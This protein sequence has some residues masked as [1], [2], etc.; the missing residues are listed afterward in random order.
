MGEAASLKIAFIIG[1]LNTGGASLLVSLLMRE[2]DRVGISVALYSLENRQQMCSEF[3]RH[4]LVCKT[5]GE[6]ADLM[7]DRVDW[8]LQQLRDF[9][10][11]TVVG[12]LGGHSFEVLRFLPKGPQRIGLI[13]A[14]DPNVFSMAARY[15]EVLDC[16]A[17]NSRTIK[18]RLDDSPHFLSLKREWCVSGVQPPTVPPPNRN[19]D[20]SLRIVT[21]SRIN[22]EQKRVHLFPEILAVLESAARP[23]VWTI[24]GD[25]PELS[26]LM[27]EMNPLA[28]FV[29]IQFT[30]S[31]QPHEV[32][33]YLYGQDVFLLT[34]DYEGQPL[35]MIHAM[36]NGVVPVVS[37]LESGIPEL[38]S[39]ATG[40]TVELNDI[41]GYAHAI[42]ELDADRVRLASMSAAARELA[43]NNYSSEAMARKWLTFLKL[44]ALGVKVEWP[45][46]FIIKAPLVDPRWWYYNPVTRIFRRWV[47][48]WSA[49]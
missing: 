40:I 44:P 49:Q 21:L 12:C 33:D 26:W 5:S 39:P 9:A 13:L 45:K 35:A 18:R 1:G 11:T 24:I 25:G 10:P 20:E 31:I 28:N 22:R 27:A 42:M 41:P 38:V 19:P 37:N 43:L 15:I 46:R 2:L 36:M 48:S 14:D 6:H 23:M 16:I 8:V 47:K 29:T 3:E 30:G 32:D 7:D 4:G 34:S 17:G